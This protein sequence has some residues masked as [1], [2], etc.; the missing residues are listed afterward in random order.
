MASVQ[1]PQ[2]LSNAIADIT[3][4]TMDSCAGVLAEKYGFPADEAKCFLESKKELVGPVLTTAKPTKAAKGKAKA[5]KTTVSEASSDSTKPKA[6]RMTG[7]L[8]FAGEN[9]PVVT[10][11]LAKDL[12]D[13]EKPKPQKVISELGARWKALDEKTKEEWN[14]KAKTPQV[15]ESSD[16]E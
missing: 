13:G 10:A 5:T 7:Y 8:L 2:M 9:R 15:S 16:S 11:D 3:K 6:K 14:S 1:I 4:Q 12:A